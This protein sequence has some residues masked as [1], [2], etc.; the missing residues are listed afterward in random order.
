MSERPSNPEPPGGAPR[1]APEPA[2]PAPTGGGASPSR[3]AVRTAQYQRWQMNLGD[4]PDEIERRRTATSTAASSSQPGLF[5]TFVEGVADGVSGTAASL[6]GVFSPGNWADL[7]RQTGQLTRAVSDPSGTASAVSAAAA[8]AAPELDVPRTV[9][10]TAGDMA[11]SAATGAVA[12][13]ALASTVRS[14]YMR[15]QMARGITDAV[16]ESPLLPAVA[17]QRPV[18]EWV[19]RRPVAAAAGVVAGAAVFVGGAADRAETAEEN[20]TSWPELA[21]PLDDAGLGELLA[22]PASR[23][24]RAAPPSAPPPVASAAASAPPVPAA[25]ESLRR[26][27]SAPASMPPPPGESGGST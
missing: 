19:A 6:A 15:T 16:M 24:V 8:S 26:S 10:R 25:A 13:L 2:A 21:A 3:A 23:A 18:A 11:G 12:A 17:R 7:S 14:P 4:H 22:T 20:R 1:P 9:A 5:A 27:S